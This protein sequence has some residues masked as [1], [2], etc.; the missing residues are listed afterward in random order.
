METLA[1]SC[2]AA[3]LRSIVAGIS[4]FAAMF[5]LLEVKEL[6][7]ESVMTDFRQRYFEADA[8]AELIMQLTSIMA[9]SDL[10]RYRIKTSY[11]GFA[12]KPSILSRETFS[13]SANA[14]IKSSTARERVAK[15]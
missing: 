12:A 9:A 6:E 10:N 5:A 3:I 7:T 4:A 15:M 13:R 1:A 2:H 11:S 8:A 14:T